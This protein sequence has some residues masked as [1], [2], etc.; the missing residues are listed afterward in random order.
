MVETNYNEMEL[1]ELFELISERS[2]ELEVLN[3]QLSIRNIGRAMQISREL[4]DICEATGFKML[5]FADAL[6]G[7][8]RRS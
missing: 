7:N 8:V 4:G 2:K 1:E 6:R 3:K 5:E